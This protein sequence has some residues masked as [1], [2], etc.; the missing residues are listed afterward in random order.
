MIAMAPPTP[1][2]DLETAQRALLARYAPD[3][4][5][6][7]LRWSAGTTQ[8]IEAGQGTP[9]LFVHGGFSQ[10]TEWLPLWPLLAGRHRLLAIDRPG[11]GLAGPHDHADGDVAALGARFL[12]DCL[13]ELGL[14]RV[15]IVG[16]SMGGRFGIELALRQPTRVERLILVGA[17]A[18]SSAA[19]PGMLL[20]LRWPMTRPM[21]RRAFRRADAASV[22]SFFARVLVRHPERVPEAFLVAKAAGQ[23]RNHASMLAFARQVMTWRGIDPSLVLSELWRRLEVPVHFVWGAEDRFD[24]PSSGRAALAAIPGGAELTEIADAGHLPWLDDPAAVA[25]AIERAVAAPRHALG[26]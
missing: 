13:D 10:A 6:R 12:A 1:L 5:V 7:P 20:A 11:H 4:L 21:V 2:P 22:R 19:V 9:L 16:G 18:G 17:P 24:P 25:A 15:A 23:R 26:G 14:D 3:A 8:I